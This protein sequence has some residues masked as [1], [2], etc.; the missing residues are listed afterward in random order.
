M[1]FTQHGCN[2]INQITLWVNLISSFLGIVFHFWL[3][4]EYHKIDSA[5]NLRFMVAVSILFLFG[6]GFGYVVIL[7]NPESYV[8]VAQN[9]FRYSSGGLILSL[10][11]TSF[12]VY[13]TFQRALEEQ[14][15]REKR[16]IVEQERKETLEFLAR[17]MRAREK[18]FEETKSTLI[19]VVGHELRTPVTVILGYMQLV[20]AG[21]YGIVPDSF[22]RPLNVINDKS[23]QIKLIVRRMQVFLRSQ[24]IIPFNLSQSVR[25]LVKSDE[26][27]T[28]TRKPPGEL[29]V[30]CIVEPGI[31]YEGDR[32]EIETAIFELLNNAIKFSPVDTDITITVTETP[33]NIAISVQDEGIGIERKH[34]RQIFDPFF[35]VRM[36]SARPFE[37]AGM[38][39]AVVSKVAENHGGFV[40]VESELGKGAI[41]TITLP[42]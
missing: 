41:F 19:N 22:E 24:D 33:E 32:D 9:V 36:D 12:L 7:S 39:L 21:D 11:I 40:D 4:F 5:K 29:N 8:F 3:L 1:A 26:V 35:Q 28:A 13:R 42:K 27:Y 38:G 15:M 16:M 2:M 30:D 23:K 14:R 20:L 18:V 6:H 31:I 17:E 34:Q 10:S 37:G 25:T